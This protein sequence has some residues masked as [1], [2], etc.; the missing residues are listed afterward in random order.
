MVQLSGNLRNSSHNEHLPRITRGTSAKIF[1]HLMSSI[2]GNPEIHF[3]AKKLNSN[4][5]KVLSGHLHSSPTAL[6]QLQWPT[7]ECCICWGTCSSGRFLWSMQ[8]LSTT[9]SASWRRVLV[10]P[11][12]SLEQSWDRTKFLIFHKFIIATAIGCL[13]HELYVNDPGLAVLLFP[14]FAKSLY[15]F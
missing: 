14:A 13:S 9:S 11:A 8:S 5:S 7:P 12:S 6:C 10:L 4:S 2:L 1:E 15:S 3:F